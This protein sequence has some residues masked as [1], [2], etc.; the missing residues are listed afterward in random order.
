MR[1]SY[2]PT[3]ILWG[4]KFEHSCVT[5]DE[6]LAKYEVSFENLNTIV[7]DNT[8]WYIYKKTLISLLKR[9]YF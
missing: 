5:Y 9:P 2:V 8:P 3:E 7:M 1:T 4:Y 6:K